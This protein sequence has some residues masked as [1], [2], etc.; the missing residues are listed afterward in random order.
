MLT[1]SKDYIDFLNKN[2]GKPIRPDGTSVPQASL[3]F[4]LAESELLNL[5]IQF[6]LETNRALMQEL[7]DFILYYNLQL[8]LNSKTWWALDCSF[9]EDKKNLYTRPA[10][11][12]F[13]I[14]HLLITPSA[15]F[16]LESKHYSAKRQFYS[17]YDVWQCYN[18]VA[19]HN[20]TATF[21]NPC[22]QVNTYGAVL[23]QIFHYYGVNLP[24]YSKV[25][26]KSEINMDYLHDSDKKDILFFDNFIDFIKSSIEN[27]KSPNRK[28]QALKLA[29]SLYYDKC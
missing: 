8:T 9:F 11:S 15:V 17:K 20:V 27:N 28:V 29:K 18:Q 14:D 5:G 23:N 2:D 12:S 19:G 7:D 3:K 21:P 1:I 24:I 22:V 25:L 16:I 13:Q 26:F 10:K 4:V 6:E